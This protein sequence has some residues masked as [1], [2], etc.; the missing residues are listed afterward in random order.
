MWGLVGVDVVGGL[1]LSAAG[2]GTEE[3]VQFG[4]H[5]T[6]SFLATRDQPRS[7]IIRPWVFPK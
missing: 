2:R 1:G 3:L 6:K 7:V 4:F 5:Q